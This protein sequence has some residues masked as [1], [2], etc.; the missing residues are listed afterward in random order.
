MAELF[1]LD[2]LDQILRAE[3]P[4]N[5]GVSAVDGLV[6]ALIAG[7]AT[8]APPLWLEPIVGKQ[9]LS[10][11]EGTETRKLLDTLI[12]HY[13]H[14]EAT[15]EKRPRR[16]R[17]QFMSDGPKVVTE[18]WSVGFIM[19]ISLGQGAWTQVLL[20]PLRDTMAPILACCE[21][22]RALLLGYPPVMISKIQDGAHYHIGD[23]V[24]AL[25]AVGRRLKQSA[26]RRRR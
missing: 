18:A 5:I 1:T 7:P 11:P 19:G 26:A 3:R 22:G 17:P 4:D 2:E 13:E 23:A 15:L 8:I 21:P 12:A 20:S 24:I 16:Y 9:A 14:I 6:A 25:H 10:E